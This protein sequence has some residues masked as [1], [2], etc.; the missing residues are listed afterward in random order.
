MFLHSAVLGY[1]QHARKMVVLLLPR[2][3]FPQCTLD[4]LTVTRRACCR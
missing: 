1:V 2:Y 3:G 4:E